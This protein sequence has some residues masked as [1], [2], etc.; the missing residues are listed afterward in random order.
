[1]GGSGQTFRESK[2]AQM[3]KFGEAVPILR[4]FAHGKVMNLAYSGDYFESDLS[5]EN[6]PVARELAKKLKAGK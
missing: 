6:A 1:M 4:C 5:W 3:E 2:E